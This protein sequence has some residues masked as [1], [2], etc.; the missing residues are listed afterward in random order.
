[1]TLVN[2]FDRITPSKNKSVFGKKNLKKGVFCCE[3]AQVQ[4][5]KKKRSILSRWRKR[6]NQASQNKP[7]TKKNKRT[8]KQRI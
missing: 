2:Y 4:S 6:K 7:R 3:K 5:G 8:K 1:L